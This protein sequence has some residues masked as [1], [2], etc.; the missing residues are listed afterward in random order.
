MKGEGVFILIAA[1]G[2]EQESEIYKNVWMFQILLAGIVGT[3]KKTH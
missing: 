2:K 3:E 1:T